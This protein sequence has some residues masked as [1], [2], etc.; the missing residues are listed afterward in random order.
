LAAE[1]T[2]I[3]GAGMTGLAAMLKDNRDVL[4]SFA[5]HMLVYALGRH[6]DWRDEPLL[7]DLVEHLVLDPSIGGLIEEIAVSEQFRRLP[8][9]VVGVDMP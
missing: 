2:W 5:R 1:N 9:P 4:R 6:L 8:S 7:D 3:L